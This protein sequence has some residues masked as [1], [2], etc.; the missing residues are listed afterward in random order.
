MREAHGRYQVEATSAPNG[1]V[2]SIHMLCGLLRMN[3]SAWAAPSLA[4][5]EPEQCRYYCH[6]TKSE[7]DHTAY[8]LDHAH[9][10]KGPITSTL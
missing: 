4:V 8:E 3:Q 5:V 9:S 10:S 7:Q 2:R 6:S 1:P